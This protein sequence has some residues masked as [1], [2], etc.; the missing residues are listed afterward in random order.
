MP[1]HAPPH[2][3]R[4]PWR[5]VIRRRWIV[6]AKHGEAGLENSTVQLHLS[7]ARERGCIFSLQEGSLRAPSAAVL[8]A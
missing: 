3:I 4:T 6:N 2:N 7:G 1:L 8:V 5:A